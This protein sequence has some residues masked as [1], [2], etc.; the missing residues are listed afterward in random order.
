MASLGTLEM[1]FL[2]IRIKSF[3]F[4]GYLSN[5]LQL[6]IPANEMHV[7]YNHLHIQ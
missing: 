5:I 3:H 7:N 2:T 6:K 4:E 1:I